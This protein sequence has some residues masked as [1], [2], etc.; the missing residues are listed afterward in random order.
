M[1]ID[2]KEEWFENVSVKVNEVEKRMVPDKLKMGKIRKN[3][4]FI[5]IVD[6]FFLQ[7]QTLC[8][9]TN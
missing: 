8:D 4:D 1:L 2:R 6:V 5:A 3:E 9:F 7:L